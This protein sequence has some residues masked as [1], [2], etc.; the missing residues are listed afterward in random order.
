MKRLSGQG[1]VQGDVGR[2]DERG[3]GR[4]APVPIPLRSDVPKIQRCEFQTATDREPGGGA[5]RL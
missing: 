3:L 5:A 4:M 2:E 1:D